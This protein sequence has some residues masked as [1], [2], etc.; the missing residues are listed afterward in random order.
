MVIPESTALARLL[1]SATGADSLGFRLP[2]PARAWARGVI[3]KRARVR[4]GC[5]RGWPPS[6]NSGSA[7]GAQAGT[8]I[9]ARQQPSV[10][11]FEDAHWADPSK[12]T[13]PQ[14]AAIQLAHLGVN[15]LSAGRYLGVAV[16]HGVIMQRTSAAQKHLARRSRRPGRRCE[17]V[18]G[19]T[20]K[21]ADRVLRLDFRERGRAALNAIDRR[22]VNILREHAADQFVGLGRLRNSCTSNAR[23]NTG[24]WD[25]CKLL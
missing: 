9:G 10:M 22:P 18:V 16:F 19:T 21:I 12:L 14:S 7:P 20:T 13:R 11:L 5:S 1:A 6:A 15:A 17:R 24:T 3:V 2:Y 4:L 25:M 23:A 8:Q